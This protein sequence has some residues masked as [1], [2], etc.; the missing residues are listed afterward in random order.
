[1]KKYILPLFD[2]QTSAAFVVCA[3]NQA[4][5]IT[6]GLTEEG[7]EVESRKMDDK[8]P[9]DTWN[10]T[11]G[12][13]AMEALVKTLMGGHELIEKTRGALHI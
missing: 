10:S 3:P 8:L 11:L 5:E 7:F 2:P 9:W 4:E 13:K 6:K 12:T 1:M